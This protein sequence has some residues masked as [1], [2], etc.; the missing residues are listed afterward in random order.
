[1]ALKGKPTLHIYLS[2]PAANETAA[3]TLFKTHVGFMKKTHAIGAI[4]TA[5]RLL[6]YS[7]AKGKERN[8]HHSQSQHLL[9]PT[10]LTPCRGSIQ[11]ILGEN[12]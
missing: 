3:D 2:V 5:P 11:K 8:D 6:E 4:G 10:S 12:L 9:H 7:I 1:M